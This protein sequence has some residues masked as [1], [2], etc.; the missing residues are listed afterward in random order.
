MQLSLENIAKCT[1]WECTA[2]IGYRHKFCLYGP[3]YTNFNEEFEFAITDNFFFVHLKLLYL[4]ILNNP[5][6]S[7]NFLW[8]FHLAYVIRGQSIVLH[9]MQISILV[10]SVLFHIIF[11]FT[12]KSSFA[13]LNSLV[14]V[15][16]IL[17][18]TL[19]RSLG[20]FTIFTRFRRIHTLT[21]SKS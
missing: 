2:G 4:K 17:K 12:E 6:Y 20:T 8:Q 1:R 11:G 16:H 10:I 9:Y 15:S 5:F 18:T 19:Y 21:W 3:S 7:W 13:P 14:R